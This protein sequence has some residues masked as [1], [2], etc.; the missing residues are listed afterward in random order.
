[1]IVKRSL[2]LFVALA[3]LAI[4]WALPGSREDID[5]VRCLELEWQSIE[6]EPLFFA[7]EREVK[8]C[9]SVGIPLPVVSP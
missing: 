1:M 2:Y 3:L 9:K 8:M 6:Y 5:R 4:L 7:T